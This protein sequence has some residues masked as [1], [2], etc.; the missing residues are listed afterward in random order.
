M[1]KDN[2]FLS[3]AHGVNNLGDHGEARPEPVFG[4][5]DRECGFGSVGARYAQNWYHRHVMSRR[6]RTNSAEHSSHG[7]KAS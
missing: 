3:D 7:P 1:P 6:A 2:D 4:V 5:G